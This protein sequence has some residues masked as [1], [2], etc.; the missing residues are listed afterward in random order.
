MDSTTKNKNW[1]MEL[2][3]KRG[4]KGLHQQADLELLNPTPY[5]A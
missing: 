3:K 5:L 4:K 1:K 2:K